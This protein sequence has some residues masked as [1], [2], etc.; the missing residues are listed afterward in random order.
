MYFDDYIIGLFDVGTGFQKIIPICKRLEKDKIIDYLKKIE[1]ETVSLFNINV[2]IIKNKIY[3]P[4]E[5]ID[6]ILSQN[7]RLILIFKLKSGE[8]Y[9]KI[10][11]KELEKCIV[12]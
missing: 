6:K 2:Y 3:I 5:V 9:Y 11:K 10:Y 4:I 8:T 1:F 12:L 7:K